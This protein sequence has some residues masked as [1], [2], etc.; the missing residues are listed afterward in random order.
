MNNSRKTE[1][2]KEKAIA[3]T[4]NLN[5]WKRVDIAAQEL[6]VSPDSIMNNI[7]EKRYPEEIYRQSLFTRVWFVWWPAV[8]GFKPDEWNLKIKT[9]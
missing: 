2:E 1:S 8:I 7:H 3:A 4:L 5:E 6:G 9:A